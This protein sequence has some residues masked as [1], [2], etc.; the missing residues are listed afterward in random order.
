MKAKHIFFLAYQWLIA[1]PVLLVLTILV[2]ISTIVLSPYLPN[3][4][5]SYMPARFWAR[6]VCFLLR[7]KV[8]VSGLE[9]LDPA[10]SCIFVLN[11]QSIFDIFVVYG[12]FPHIFK[13]MMKAELRR[14]PF[15]GKAC[16]SAGHIFIDRS[17]PVAARRS[18]QIAESQLKNGVSL[19][20]FPEG[21]RTRTGR[22][23]PF[24]R[25]AFRIATDLSLPVVPVTLRGSF[26]RFHG[27]S[28]HVN[29]GTIEAIVH[30]PIDV[31]PYL[32][33]DISSLIQTTWQA[34][35]DGL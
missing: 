24:K 1:V 21:T 32:P 16:E 35:N 18:L 17:S 19:V 27:N 15:V 28:L 25:G 34:V 9:K 6:A 22:M 23:N 11:H 13:W 33:D 26:D 5:L 4:P 20:I 2:A 12:W 29:P 31:T 14:I 3:S 8:S 30:S 10:Q 7:V